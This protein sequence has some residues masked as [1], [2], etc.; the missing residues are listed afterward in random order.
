M[1]TDHSPDLNPIELA[2]SKFKKLL[3]DGAQRT[4]DK[5]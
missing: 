5:L 4:T 1:K 2:F 3:R